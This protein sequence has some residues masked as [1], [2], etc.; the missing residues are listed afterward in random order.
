MGP[1]IECGPRPGLLARNS[2]S[3]LIGTPG[4]NSF[5]KC[6]QVFGKLTQSPDSTVRMGG[7]F[8]SNTPSRTVFLFESTTWMGPPP[9]LVAAAGIAGPRRLG[10]P[11][12]PGS[13]GGERA[14]ETARPQQLTPRPPACAKK[15][16]EPHLVHFVHVTPVPFSSPQP[17]NPPQS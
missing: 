1:M 6:D 11:T 4:S 13:D 8:A 16:I 15:T 2:A 14:H 17:N 3:R 9:L 10:E 7:K 5:I 12:E